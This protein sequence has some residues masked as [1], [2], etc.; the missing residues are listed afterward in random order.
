MKHFSSFGPEVLNLPIFRFLPNRPPEIGAVRGPDGTVSNVRESGGGGNAR[1]IVQAEAARGRRECAWQISCLTPAQWK[2][3]LYPP[4][5]SERLGRSRQELGGL[6]ISKAALPA[7]QRH[8]VH[9]LVKSHGN[10]EPVV[11]LPATSGG[12]Q[13]PM[14]GGRAEEGEGG[15][16]AAEENHPNNNDEEEDRTALFTS[17]VATTATTTTTTPNNLSSSSISANA[18]GDTLGLDPTVSGVTYSK[19]GGIYGHFFRDL[20]E[21]VRA[22]VLERYQHNKQLI[23]LEG[24][25]TTPVAATATTT[26]TPALPPSMTQ[27]QPRP[28]FQPKTNLSRLRTRIQAEKEGLAEPDRG[29]MTPSEMREEVIISN[30]RIE[31]WTIRLQRV[32]RQYMI[33]HDMLIYGNVYN[34]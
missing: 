21:D 31:Q 6:G 29:T 3:H 24:H 17:S 33:I 7:S 10:K 5:L 16:V 34:H 32:R 15:E 18:L 1:S 20:S 25:A 19:L 30:K 8:R 26:T 9:Q 2:P 4:V 13:M 27:T 28:S 11:T 22:L 23:R 14:T 12:E